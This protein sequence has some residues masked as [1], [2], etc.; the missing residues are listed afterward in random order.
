MREART[1]LVQGRQQLGLTHRL[2]RQAQKLRP[3]TRSSG[4]MTACGA[5]A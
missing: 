2:Y 1:C 4:L 3:G 5:N